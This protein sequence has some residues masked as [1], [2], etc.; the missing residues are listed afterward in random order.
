MDRDRNGADAR[1]AQL[2]RSGRRSRT[3][4]GLAEKASESG[5][6]AYIA[7]LEEPRGQAPQVLPG[8]SG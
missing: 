7:I 6:E 3:T 1:L 4:R 5:V 2:A 8:M